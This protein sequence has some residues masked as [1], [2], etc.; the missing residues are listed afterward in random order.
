MRFFI[1]SSLSLHALKCRGLT[2]NIPL[3]LSRI[4]NIN[5]VVM[6]FR[7]GNICCK[8]AILNVL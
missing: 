5:S 7:L 1:F 6:V 8:F 2:C 4:Y 3:N